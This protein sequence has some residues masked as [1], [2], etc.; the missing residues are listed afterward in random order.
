MAAF[1]P[2]TV[3]EV[4]PE[5]RDAIVVTLHP[6]A[7]HAELFRFRQGQYLTLRAQLDGE[8]VRRSYSICSAVQDGTLR[9][10]IKRVKDGWFSSWANESLKAG[11][12]IEAMP[13]AGNFFV[14]LDPAQRRHYVGFAG[15]SGIT[16]LL[17]IVKT[18]L[19]SE[20]RSR[21]TL[22]YGN[23]ASSTIM[24]REELEDLKNEFI[25]RFNLVHILNRE[26]QDVEL[27]NGMLTREKCNALFRHWLDLSD[28]DTAFICGPQPMMLAVAEA[29]QE[30][31]LDRSKIKFELFSSPAGS[32]RPKASRE[33]IGDDM[34]RDQCE[35]T[36]IIDGRSRTFT[37]AKKGES[38]LD[39]GL[40]EGLEL[41][42]ACKGGVCS[43]CR[44]ML[45]EGEVDMDANFAL[46]DYEIARGYILTC[47]SFP[48]T[49]RIVVDYDQ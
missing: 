26:H 24:F 30:N 36:V 15:G 14:P 21:F 13:P 12:R 42:Y 8:E 9:V 16:P 32:A 27:F 47:Q 40:K 4:R 43:T 28:V 41:P 45:L 6:K 7:E 1:Y 10:G 39:S 35:A 49:D 29:L 11:M 2:L 44:A 22:F 34:A 38:V 5:T 19:L 25:E 23:E 31:G 3:T 48:A 17:G 37:M 33:A 46:E 18:T 20:L